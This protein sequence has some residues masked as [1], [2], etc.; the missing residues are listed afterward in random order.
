M[1][2]DGKKTDHRLS[3]TR[4]D[5]DRGVLEA[6]LTDGT[7]TTQKLAIGADGAASVKVTGSTVQIP[8]YGWQEGG[9]E[10]APDVSF[11]LGVKIDPA[12]GAMTTMWWDGFVWREVA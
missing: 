12:T 7:T 8:E 4:V 6:I 2:S 11:A 9:A 3:V 10:P 1:S 5:D